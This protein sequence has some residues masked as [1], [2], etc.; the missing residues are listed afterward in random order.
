MNR[1]GLLLALVLT[2]CIDLPT[3][4]PT[5]RRAPAPVIELPTPPP[6]PPPPV[7]PPPSAE[8]E[9]MRQLTEL[10]GY[11]Q[12]VAQM[13]AEEQRRELNAAIQAFNR[14]RSSYNRLRL[15]LLHLLPG[16]AFQDDT[17][18]VQLLEPLVGSGNGTVPKLASLLYTQ[19][20]E[21][22][23]TQRRAD[24]MKEQLDALR[25]IERSLIDRGQES[26]PRKP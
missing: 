8:T 25:E 9:D 10:L 15:A 6:P 20:G 18:A 14:D 11:Y 16:T 13:G 2:A 21:R 22:M 4:P 26:V 24:Q 7:Q 17:R 1:T 19:V 3:Q 5:E 23:K 12:R